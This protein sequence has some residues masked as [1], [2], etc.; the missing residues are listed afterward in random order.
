METLAQ[1]A[2]GFSI[3]F[4]DQVYPHPFVPTK[5]LIWNL[6]D[7][8][9]VLIKENWQ[10]L[11]AFVPHSGGPRWCE[12]FEKAPVALMDWLHGVGFVDKGES[13]HIHL[14]VP[15]KEGDHTFSNPFTIILEG[16]NPAFIEFLLE[17]CVIPLATKGATFY[18]HS[19]NP[20]S[21]SWVVTNF[22]AGWNCHITNNPAHLK[23]VLAWILEKLYGCKA[24][25]TIAHFIQQNHPLDTEI[26]KLTPA[27]IIYKA[28][29]SYCMVYI[30]DVNRSGEAEPR[31]QLQGEPVSTNPEEQ[32]VWLNAVQQ[33]KFNIGYEELFINKQVI[34]CVWCKQENHARFTCPYLTHGEG[35]LRMSNNEIKEFHDSC[36]D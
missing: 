6:A 3:P 14:P 35:W 8:K 25:Q 32:R 21:L 24:L 30:E 9:R 17:Q 12:F 28:T 10:E 27:E 18:A 7:F 19:L 4:T 20:S 15:Q 31:Y 23:E 29:K 26:T 34:Q 1:K 16:A 13:L 2:A 5:E 22:K 11:V 33:V 36:A